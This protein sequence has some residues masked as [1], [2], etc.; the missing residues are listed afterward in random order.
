MDAFPIYLRISTEAEQP[1]LRSQSCAETV[2]AALLQ[3]QASGW[4]ALHGFVVLPE[5][6]ELIGTPLAPSIGALVGGIVAATAPLLDVLTPTSGQLWSRCFMRTPLPTA[7]AF[8]TRLS[9]LLLTPVARGL[10]TTPAGYPYSSAHP[11]SASATTACTRYIPVS[12]PAH[13]AAADI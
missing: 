8:E 7:R 5:A 3:I 9:I 10:A 4:L 2:I 12:P 1:L 6:L 13:P 11:R